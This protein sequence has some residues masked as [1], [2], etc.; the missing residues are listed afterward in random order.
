MENKWNVWSQWGAQWSWESCKQYLRFNFLKAETHRQRQL[1]TP[2]TDTAKLN[3]SPCA[4]PSEV[5]TASYLMPIFVPEQ[6]QLSPAASQHTQ[7][8]A[9]PLASE[10][11]GMEP[12]VH[13]LLIAQAYLILN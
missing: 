3:L 9:K 6:K 10:G 5:Q 7:T 12:C 8:H 2:A 13:H 1:T 4:R 11:V